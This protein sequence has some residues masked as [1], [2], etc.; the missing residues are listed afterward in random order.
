MQLDFYKY[1]GTGN[2]FVVIDDRN[3]H[4]NVNNKQKI[5]KICDRR[6]GIGA[7]GLILLRKHQ[8]ADF[9]MLYFNS[10]GN[11]GTMCGNGARCL[12]DF[13]HFLGIIDDNCTFFAS[14]D[15]YEAKWTN[16]NIELKMIDVCEVEVN[17]DFIYLNTGSPHYVK[18]V[19]DLENYPVYEEGISIRYNERFSQNGTNVNFVEIQGSKC[20]VRT[21]E[22]GV[23]D[24]TFS[25]GT[26]AVAVAIAAHATN[27][28]LDNPLLIS[29]LGGNLK[30]LFEVVDSVYKN[31][32]LIGPAKRVFKG[33]MKC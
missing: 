12:V 18:F 23:E 27:K 15:F 31:V 6:K 22:R 25:C 26:G 8:K 3:C 32:W 2:D 14:N 9:E 1:Q 24:E 13:A 21:Y 29:V 4:F 7:D 20:R 16:E 17:D 33:S 19:K 28:K 30:V 11:I 10:D 5:R